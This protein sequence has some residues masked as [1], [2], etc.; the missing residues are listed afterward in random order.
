LKKYR[1]NS[2]IDRRRKMFIGIPINVMRQY[3]AFQEGLQYCWAACT[4]MILRLYGEER[5]QSEID[6][7]GNGPNLFGWFPDRSGHSFSI[8]YNF[9]EPFISRFHCIPGEDAP[10]PD[11]LLDE[12][13]NHRPM[14]VG[15]DESPQDRHAIVIFG[16]D[17][18]QTNGWNVIQS[19]HVADPF[20]GRGIRFWP[21]EQL[22]QSIFAHWRIYD[23]YN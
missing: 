1:I 11:V 19:I 9:N 22:C 8:E 20:P 4:Q 16:A 23:N 10:P 21:A 14:I 15:Y 7:R 2:I 6:I 18:I 17:C 13:E 3:L 12:L 5:T